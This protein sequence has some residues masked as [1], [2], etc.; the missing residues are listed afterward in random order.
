MTDK[1]QLSLAAL[2]MTLIALFFWTQSRVPALDQK[3][4]MGQR[5]TISSIAFDVVL[6]VSSDQPYLERVARSAANWAYTNWKGMTFG[7]IFAAAF[8]TFLRLLPSFAD[9]RFKFINALKGMVIGIPLGVCANCSTPI[10]HGMVRAG[11][12]LETALATL[13]S[14]PTLN[15]IVLTMTFSLLPFHVALAKVFGVVFMVLIVL[16]LLIKL[17]AN[18]D[19]EQKG[20]A[21]SE[22]TKNNNLSSIQLN[23]DGCEIP[24]NAWPEAIKRVLTKLLTNFALVIRETLPLMLVAGVLGAFAIES[25]PFTNIVDMNTGL[26]ALVLISIVGAF[27]PV[28]IAFDVIIVVTLLTAGM[29]VGL[30][31]G[32]LFSLGIFSIYPAMVIARQISL[33]L[34]GALFTMVVLTSVAVGATTELVDQ[35]KI[36]SAKSIITEELKLTEKV[37][38]QGDLIREECLK[39]AYQQSS[40]D[41]FKGVSEQLKKDQPD[42]PQDPT[43]CNQLQGMAQH[44]CMALVS[45]S[46]VVKTGDIT[47]CSI[48]PIPTNKQRCEHKIIA[49]KVNALLQ[50]EALTQ[51]PQASTTEVPA[52]K[53]GASLSMPKEATTKFNWQWQE[54]YNDKLIRVE[55]SPVNTIES[56]SFRF[57]KVDANNI[58]INLPFE[59]RL[60]DFYEPF[61]YGRGT[62]SGDINNDGLPDLVFGT[63]N[64]PRVFKNSGNGQFQH[65]SI[66]LGALD[67]RNTFVVAFADINNDGW[68]D[69]FFSTYSGTSY[70]IPNS[71]GMFVTQQARKIE[72]KTSLTMAAGFY[73]MDLDGDLD[74]L[75]GNWTAGAENHFDTTYSANTWVTTTDQGFDLTEDQDQAGETLSVLFSD[76]LGDRSLDAVIANDNLGPD[77]YYRG[78]KNKLETISVD[79]N[80][81]PVTSL[82]TMSVDSADFNNDLRLDIFTSDMSFGDGEIDNYCSLLESGR[83]QQCELLLK[84]WKDIQALSTAACQTYSNKPD[85]LSAA[86]IHLAKSTKDPKL[87]GNLARHEKGLI[88]LCTI[89][90]SKLGAKQPVLTDFIHQEQA[91][92]LLLNK[93]D[94]FEDV[95]E[96]MQ[97]N[98]SFWSW[99]SKAADLDNDG[100]IDLLIA[101]GFGFGEQQNEIHSNVFFHNQSGVSFARKTEEFGLKQLLNTPSYTYVDLDLDGDLDIVA[102]AIMENPQIHINQSKKNR[103]V[104]ELR[105][106]QKNRYCIGCKVTISL[107]GEGGISQQ[108]REI[109][110]SGGFMSFDYPAAYF[111]L[112]NINTVTKIKV[113]WSDGEAF[114]FKQSVP[115]NQV[116]RITRKR[117]DLIAE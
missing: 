1:K 76:F 93:G 31:S 37:D 95:S 17:I 26:L 91:N 23:S 88:Q 63:A 49:N 81:V 35:Q 94:K 11:T 42:A 21:L 62:A 10:A 92:K 99:N 53:H 90:S 8:I 111:G 9:S 86:L 113:E 72:A 32:L 57:N 104:V 15:I 51:Q 66:D 14:S 20:A 78:T 71:Q 28:P 44:E 48:I 70:V 73:D 100:W 39:I 50:L 4:Q 22:V 58:G 69:L 65:V 101:N 116:V 43:K 61:K 5:T 30:A 41:C 112:N 87:C 24:S 103:L 25:L 108:L 64:G 110:L 98:N 29:S 97:I 45:E 33:K 16:P 47:K 13:M 59:F 109:K 107:A 106:L 85:C 12:K 114:E 19:M 96:Q 77:I 34:S 52:K 75:L 3:A 40:Q 80:L 60:S 105:D 83:Q 38:R 102:G 79:S 6:P 67:S 68:Q 84:A 115:S 7:L 74:F 89:V 56:S 46:F 36:D 54:I 82:T 18:K 117:A 27:L 2:L 55:S